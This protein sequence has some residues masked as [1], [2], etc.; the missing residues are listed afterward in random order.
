MPLDDA[1]CGDEQVEPVETR[2]RDL[3]RI[4]RGDV[5]LLTVDPS[6]VVPVGLQ[7]VSDGGADAG[8][9]TGDDG[10]LQQRAAAASTRST[11]SSVCAVQRTECS[12]G[13]GDA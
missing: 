3:R 8:G 6:D 1:G 12:A 7:P 13:E 10:G 11:S 2:E 4:G 9:R 5:A